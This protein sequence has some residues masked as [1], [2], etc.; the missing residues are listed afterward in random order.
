MNIK[1]PQI[2]K[3]YLK[4]LSPKNHNPLPSFP[5]TA[6]D[7]TYNKPKHVFIGNKGQNPKKISIK[8]Y[9]KTKSK[10]NKF[11]AKKKIS[12]N[13][14]KSSKINRMTEYEKNNNIKILIK[15]EIIN[16]N[17]NHFYNLQMQKPFIQQKIEMFDHANYIYNSNLGNNLVTE[18]TPIFL[19]EVPKK[20]FVYD[21]F[22]FS[23][24]TELKPE[25]IIKQKLRKGKTTE[26]NEYFYFV[27]L[28]F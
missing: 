28:I 9:T 2:H 20:H 25:D 24:S 13:E 27:I 26:S 10:L 5:K 21:D 1:K 16:N 23:Q 19:D 3:K 14:R 15:N 11:N 18:N 12:A 7:K 17:N 8:N 22:G 6:I 4:N